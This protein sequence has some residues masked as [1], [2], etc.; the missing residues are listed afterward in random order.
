M[1]ADEPGIKDDIVG[2][3]GKSGT[4]VKFEATEGFRAY[5]QTHMRGMAQT[6]PAS[7]PFLPQ[8]EL[9]G[10]Q[11]HEELSETKLE[12]VAKGTAAAASAPSP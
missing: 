8:P 1:E 7:P 3:L 6:A 12:I 11:M 10:L 4:R 5:R 9:G 2:V